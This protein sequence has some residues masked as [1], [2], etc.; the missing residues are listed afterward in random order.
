MDFSKDYL[1][2]IAKELKKIFNFGTTFIKEWKLMADFKYTFKNLITQKYL[3]P[4]LLVDEENEYIQAQAAMLRQKSKE[5]T[6]ITMSKFVKTYIRFSYDVTNLPWQVRTASN[7]LIRNYGVCADYSILLTALFRAVNIPARLVEGK[8]SGGGHLWVEVYYNKKWLV[9]DP[10]N[11]FLDKEWDS[12]GAQL[13]LR[14]ILER[15][16]GARIVD[17]NSEDPF[18]ITS[19]IP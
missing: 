18:F 15:E 9:I 4:S 11:T 8:L 19:F 1:N 3:K 6:I 17:E 10:T 13:S 14:T 5:E 2:E 7:T 16:G 12:E